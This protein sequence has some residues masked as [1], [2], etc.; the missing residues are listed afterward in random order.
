MHRISRDKSF[1][2]EFYIELR[3]FSKRKRKSF[4]FEKEMEFFRIFSKRNGNLS[5]V[6]E[7]ICYLFHSLAPPLLF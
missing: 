2:T 3:M 6:F 1:K 5:Y 4:V 7:K